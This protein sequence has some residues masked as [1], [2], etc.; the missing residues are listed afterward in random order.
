VAAARLEGLPV[1]HGSVLSD[2]AD[3]ELELPGIGKIFA[4]TANDEVNALSARHFVHLFGR[5]NL[6]QLSPARKPTEGSAELGSEF[7]TRVLFGAELTYD[8]LQRRFEAGYE[9][10]GT[11]LTKQFGL[12]K[13]RR[14]HG[15]DAIPILTVDEGSDVTVATRDKSL[16]P[17]PGDT[18]LALAP[19]EPVKVEARKE[20]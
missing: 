11:P 1:Y 9:F 14:A 20:G 5:E 7:R 17:E 10:R 12:E 8:E 3:E 19:P 16:A 2:Q 6:F 15:P 18:L 13:W 4:L